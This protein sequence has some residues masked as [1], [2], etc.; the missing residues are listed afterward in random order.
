MDLR[1]AIR[2]F[3]RQPW[4]TAGAIA[5]LAVG[6]GVNSTIFTLANG[7]LFRAMP[8]IVDPGRLVWISTTAL[9]RDVRASYPDFLDYAE[10]TRDLIDA[11]AFQPA[12]LSM[13][14]GEEPQ[15]IRGHLVTGRYF[16]ALGIRPALGRL[17]DQTDERPDGPHAVVVSHLLW[18]RLFRGSPEAIRRTL[19]LNGSTFDV[20][21]VAPEHFAGPALG[22]AAD[23][24][25]S[26]AMAPVLRSADRDLLVRR[27]A[28]WLLMM[29]RLRPGVAVR[30]MEAAARTVAAGIEQAYPNPDMP[31]GVSIRPAGW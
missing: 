25:L 12:P 27:D 13:G 30:S 15:R 22:E 20:V 16:E 17:L 29:G 10:G 14:T 24:W 3:F 28:G 31:R 11:F 2:G 21:G 5:T 26:V 9:G 4:F 8:G 19:T 18:Q 1:Y 7:A 23:V 6:I